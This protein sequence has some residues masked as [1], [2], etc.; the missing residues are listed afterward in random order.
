[1]AESRRKRAR[2][3][4]RQSW[5]VLRDDRRLLVFPIVSALANLLIGAIVWGAAFG[6]VHQSHQYRTV[7]IVGG[8]IASFPA[9][10]VSYYSGVALATV[11]ARK[12]D[13]TP[14]TAADGWKAARERIGIIAAWTVLVCTVG[15]ILRLLEEYL[16][17]A[18]RIAVWLLDASWALATMF[19]VPVLAY[20]G[21]GPR[22][23]LSRSVEIFKDRWGEQVAGV[24]LIGFGTA[25]LA[26]PA[27]ILIVAGFAAG[28][29][30]GI[31]LVAVGGAALLAVAAYSTALNQVYRVFLY[32]SV[33]KDPAEPSAATSPFSAE[34]LASPF[35]PRR[36]SWAR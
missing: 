28:G 32:R 21:L 10:F 20:E 1:M 34:D 13:G 6:I 15:A 17:A 9:T 2:R 8:I 19:A 23:T 22:A 26:I 5:Q 3:L 31:V 24:L 33:V 30:L 29:A 14:V 18:G 36:S 25:F 27:V 12:L 7:F 11:L 4:G 16:P 35:R